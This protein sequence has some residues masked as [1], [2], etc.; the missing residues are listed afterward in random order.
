MA[1]KIDRE[2]LIIYLENLRVL[3]TIHCLCERKIQDLENRKNKIVFNQGSPPSKPLTYSEPSKPG[4]SQL[5]GPIIGFTLWGGILIPSFGIAIIEEI[6]GVPV[7]GIINKLIT[8]GVA[9]G[10]IVGLMYGKSNYTRLKNNYNEDIENLKQ[11]KIQMTQE[12]QKELEKYQQWKKEALIKY[13]KQQKNFE[14]VI[15]KVYDEKWAVSDAL[16]EAYSM[17]IIP[18]QFRNIQGIYYLYD[19]I[20]TS[21]ESLSN[22]LLQANLEEIKRRLDEIIRLESEQIILEEQW[23]MEERQYNQ[24]MLEFS[25]E[26]A[27]NSRLSSQYGEIA[28]LNSETSLQ[29]QEEQLAYQKADYWAKKLGLY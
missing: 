24:R 11:K 28:A 3:E 16:E 4:I 21:N 5:I 10:L 2:A 8:F 27:E 12:Y 7:G 22:A 14:T 13:N 20:S 1:N 26:T 15:N 18:K 6:L 23:H 17:N 19:Y 25:Q 9:A 29:L